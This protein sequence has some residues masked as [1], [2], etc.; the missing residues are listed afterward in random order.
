MNSKKKTEFIEKI[1]HFL[2]QLDKSIAKDDTLV[3]PEIQKAYKMINQPEKVSQQYNQVHDAIA[4]MNI[5]FQNLAVSKKY[6]FS[7]EQ[8]ELINELKTLSRRSLKDSFIGVINGA[9]MH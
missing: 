9:V 7:S 4:D 6:H 3:K 1:N 8:N 2:E 5:A